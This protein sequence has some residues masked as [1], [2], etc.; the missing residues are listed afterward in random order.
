M[1]FDGA[2]IIASD[3]PPTDD[4]LVVY[5]DRDKHI[6]AET[7]ARGQ[8]PIRMNLE[9]VTERSGMCKLGHTVKLKKHDKFPDDLIQDP[10]CVYVCICVGVCM[11]KSVCRYSVCVCS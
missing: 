5:E 7:P 9:A 6:H 8:L 3:G 4:V 11:C 10:R 1:S 2:G